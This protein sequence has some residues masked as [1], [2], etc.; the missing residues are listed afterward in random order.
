MAAEF[1][2]TIEGRAQGKFLGESTR[3]PNKIAGLALKYEVTSPHDPR[4]GL[5]TGRTQHEPVTLVK[6][7]GAASP[8]LYN[9]TVNNED[10]T[11]VVFEFVKTTPDGVEA[12]YHTIKLTNASVASISLNVD[13]PTPGAPGDTHELEEVTFYFQQIELSNIGGGTTAAAGPGISVLRGAEAAL[14]TRVEAGGPSLMEEKGRVALATPV[15][16]GST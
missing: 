8:Q 3:Y 9:A 13:A 4:T 14:L 5:P 16:R 12:V 7:W 6:E 10:L 15:L 2:V 11:S 1:Y